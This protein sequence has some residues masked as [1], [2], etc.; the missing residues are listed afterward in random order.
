MARCSIGDTLTIT[1]TVTELLPKPRHGG[2][3][4]I[5]VAVN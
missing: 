4:V 5:A 2:G 1:S 3:I